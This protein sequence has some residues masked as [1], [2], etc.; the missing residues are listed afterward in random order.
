MNGWSWLGGA[1]GLVSLVIIV[2]RL[3]LGTSLE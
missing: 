1:K 2:A 3:A